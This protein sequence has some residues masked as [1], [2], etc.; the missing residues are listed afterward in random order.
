[1]KASYPIDPIELNTSDDTTNIGICQIYWDDLRAVGL[2]TVFQIVDLNTL[3]GRLFA[4]TGDVIAL[5][6]AGSDEPND[7]K[8]VYRSCGS[9]HAYRYS[10]C[11]EP[12]PIDLRIDTLLALGAGT[13]DL[14]E[15]FD[16]YEEYQRLV[17]GQ[18]GFLYTVAQRF[19]YAYAE[20]VGNAFKS[21]PAS[22]ADGNSGRLNELCFDRR[23]KLK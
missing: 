5:S 1:M 6:F 19:M 17:A 7:G 8:N 13:F 11:E 4:A 15:A 2:K 20:H 22:I 16:H 9:L 23:L 18:L 14:A 12:N 3:I 10:A 21:A